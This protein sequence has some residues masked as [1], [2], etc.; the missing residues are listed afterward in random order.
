MP[1]QQKRR[2]WEVEERE[3]TSK[4]QE[5]DTN[6]SLRPP[7]LPSEPSP[8]NTS[9]CHSHSHSPLSLPFVPNDYDDDSLR[10]HEAERPLPPIDPTGGGEMQWDSSVGEIMPES[11][12]VCFG[13]V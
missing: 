4:R 7:L 1:S 6:T 5:P 10:D 9:Y 13:M 2:I 8:S 11:A 3:S 12:F